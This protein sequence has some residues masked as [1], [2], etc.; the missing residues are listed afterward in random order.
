MAEDVNFPLDQVRSTGAFQGFR[1]AAEA[2]GRPRRLEDRE[3]ELNGPDEQQ[4]L[5]NELANLEA[6]SALSSPSRIR[7]EARPEAQNPT[8]DQNQEPQQDIAAAERSE[9]QA[10]RQVSEDARTDS[11]NPRS[12]GP[13]GANELARVSEGAVQ[14]PDERLEEGFRIGNEVANPNAI[15]E[16]QS[17]NQAENVRKAFQQA[18]ENVASVEQENL[19]SQV[20]NEPTLRDLP[21]EGTGPEGHE[22]LEQIIAPNLPRPEETQRA[23]LQENRVDASGTKIQKQVNEAKAE[24]AREAVRNE[25]AIEIPS[26]KIE[27]VEPPEKPIEEGQDVNPLRGPR[28]SELRDESDASAVET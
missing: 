24:K 16:F 18:N 9:L 20:R 23:E 15:E 8:D 27:Q 6:R 19:A 11:R 13:A 5:V 2:T 17:G 4:G 7:T 21:K 25:P 28:P 3:E 14:E 12:Q 1:E 10:N 22:A 26:Q